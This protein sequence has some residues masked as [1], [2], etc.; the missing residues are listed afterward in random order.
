MD[1]LHPQI[2]FMARKEERKGKDQCKKRKEERKISRV[3]E[4][5]ATKEEEFWRRRMEE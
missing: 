5:K 3:K 2:E 1:P 4:K